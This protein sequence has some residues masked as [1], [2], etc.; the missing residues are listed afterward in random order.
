MKEKKEKKS[1]FWKPGDKKPENAAPSSKPSKSPFNKSQNS[2]S[3]SNNDDISNINGPMP[4]WNKSR[5][6]ISDIFPTV[7]SL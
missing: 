6:T 1:N 5:P 7:K 4:A 3:N 2:N